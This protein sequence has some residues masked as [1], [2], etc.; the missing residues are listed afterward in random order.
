V[1][2]HYLTQSVKLFWRR[3]L[4]GNSGLR[5]KKNHVNVSSQP[6][7]VSEI[8]ARVIGI[9]VNGDWIT[10]P[11]PIHYVGPVFGCNLKVIAVEPESLTVATLN[12]KY[13]TRSKAEPELAV[14]EWVV[15]VGNVLMLDPLLPFNVRPGGRGSAALLRPATLWLPT[16][17]L[18][19]FRLWRSAAGL[20]PCRLW[21]SAS[22]RRPRL[23]R[24]ARRAMLRKVLRA[25]LAAALLSRFS[26]TASRL[27]IQV[28][29]YISK[30][31]HC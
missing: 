21:R 18:R 11:V 28:L 27:R 8:I 1:E 14:R 9:L 4:A 2:L 19:S 5:S 25:S 20:R 24:A 13:M 30:Q 6:A 22:R 17:S 12:M 7:V 3:P 16:A 10:I 29:T 23:R 26:L 31:T 15:H